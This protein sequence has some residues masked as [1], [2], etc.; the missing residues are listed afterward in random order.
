MTEATPSSSKALAEETWR[1]LTSGAQDLYN[2]GEYTESLAAHRGALRYAQTNEL[3]RRVIESRISSA[4]VA[5][6]LGLLPEAPAHLA[7]LLDDGDLELDAERRV[8]RLL[9]NLFELEGDYAAAH[10]YLERAG[11]FVEPTNWTGQ[12]WWRQHHVEVLLFLDKL[13][14][15]KSSVAKATALI[16]KGARDPEACTNVVLIRQSQIDRYEGNL[17]L[18]VDR[19]LEGYAGLLGRGTPLVAITAC[20]ALAG[21][22]MAAERYE[23]TIEVISSAEHVP[24]E[25]ILRTRAAQI[26]F[27]ALMKLD[28]WKEASIQLDV[29]IAAEQQR[30]TNAHNVYL[31]QA[32]IEAGEELRDQNFLIAEANQVLTEANNDRAQLMELVG[33]DLHDQLTATANAWQALKANTNTQQRQQLFHATNELVSDLTSTAS[34]VVEMRIVEAQ[35]LQLTWETLRLRTLLNSAVKSVPLA[36]SLTINNTVP[37]SAQI[38]TDAGQFVSA[39]RH[40]ITAFIPQQ[41]EPTSPP[42]QMISFDIATNQPKSAVELVIRGSRQA[43]D[44]RAEPQ[45]TTSLEFETQVETSKTNHRFINLYLGQSL[46]R[47]IGFDV[48]LLRQN[49][50]EIVI[51]ARCDSAN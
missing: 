38:S 4:H 22:L 47:C 6:N 20:N 43:G 36:E 32:E 21:H 30:N 18:A 3:K 27:E 14:E 1:A 24:M 41:G 16:A 29:V 26:R 33:S 9:S 40:L 50:G 49:D 31:L 46:L 10:S 34:K 25:H 13:D 23:E 51:N 12:F 28:R 39:L 44:I 37:W 42:A 48:T 7:N 35:Q 45:P 11:Q 19:A 8:C 15:A 5:I 2:K 17:A